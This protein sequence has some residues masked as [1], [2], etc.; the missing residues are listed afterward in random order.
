M[1]DGFDRMTL[2]LELGAMAKQA[3]K[4]GDTP[5][6]ATLRATV[7][8]LVHDQPIVAAHEAQA[9]DEQRRADERRESDKLRKRRVRSRPQESNGQDGIQRTGDVPA[10]APQG[11]PG[12]LPSTLTTTATS[13]SPARVWQSDTE[14]ALADLL[15][16]D[17]GRD[18]LANV[19]DVVSMN[20]GTRFGVVAEIQACLAGDRGPQFKA[21]AEQLDVAL[22]DY[23][24]NGLSSRRWNS[25][26]FRACI[27]RAMAAPKEPA[28]RS[29][30]PRQPVYEHWTE[31]KAREDSQESER[32][33]NVGLVEARRAKGDGEM[34][35]ER[36]QREAGTTDRLALYRYAAARI[37]EDGRA[38]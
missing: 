27:T 29:V 1:A 25:A 37:H 23:S 34:W 38:A 3:E 4:R 7:E 9:A 19:L 20:G 35:W 18:A 30:T 8:L 17:A 2:I 12:P 26:H 21:T 10:D 24:T 28:G 15:R 33:R 13:S 5:S 32:K 16:T 14:Q 6:A 36:M 31:R 11:F 22:S